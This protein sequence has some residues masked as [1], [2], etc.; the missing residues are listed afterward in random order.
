M[1]YFGTG[2]QRDHSHYT[3]VSQIL[4][5]LCPQ[6]RSDEDDPLT[7]IML[8]CRAVRAWWEEPHGDAV[9]PPPAPLLPPSPGHPVQGIVVAGLAYWWVLPLRPPSLPSR[10]LPG[11][12]VTVLG[13][14]GRAS[15]LDHMGHVMWIYCMYTRYVQYVLSTLWLFRIS[16]FRKWIKIPNHGVLHKFPW[17]Y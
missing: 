8:Q 17:A 16:Q 11:I 3:Q 9:S 7:Q 1:T 4:H 12:G 6:L 14:P 2:V 15:E 5:W 10:L 13:L